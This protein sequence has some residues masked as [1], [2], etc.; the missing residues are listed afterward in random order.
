ML[1]AHHGLSHGGTIVVPAGPSWW[2]AVLAPGKAHCGQ[3]KIVR[4]TL[5]MSPLSLWSKGWFS[6]TLEYWEL[7]SDVYL[8]STEVE[9]PAS[10]CWWCHPSVISIFLMSPAKNKCFPMYMYVYLC[11]FICVCTNMHTNI[12]YA[13]SPWNALLKSCTSRSSKIKL[14]IVTN[15]FG[16]KGYSIGFLFCHATCLVGY[17]YTAFVPFTFFQFYPHVLVLSPEN[18]SGIYSINV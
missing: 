4:L 5:L 9:L 13:Y 7:P 18:S 15:S 1:G 14:L 16:V 12:G 17:H 11:M 2:S 8:R 10:P 3:T 6:L